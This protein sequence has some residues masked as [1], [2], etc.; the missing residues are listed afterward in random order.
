[1]SSLI[2]QSDLTRSTDQKPWYDTNVKKISIPNHLVTRRKTG[3]QIAAN[4][5]KKDSKHD[6]YLESSGSFN[7]VSFGGS[8]N[9]K[10]VGSDNRSRTGISSN[11]HD[12][13]IADISKYDETTNKTINDDLGGY[14]LGMDLPPSKSI[15]DLNDEILLSLDNPTPSDTFLTKDPKTY[16]NVFNAIVPGKLE[17]KEETLTI[18]PLDNCESAIVV[19]GYPERMANQVIQQFQLFGTILEEFEMNKVKQKYFT[20]PDKI[21]PIFSGP[22]WVKI[23]Y[24]NPA[25]ARDALQQNGT[26]FNGVILGVVPYT[27]DAIEKLQNR[28]LADYEDI[29]NSSNS[30]SYIQPHTPEITPGTKVSPSPKLATQSNVTKLDPKENNNVFLNNSNNDPTKPVDGN[31]KLSY[32]DRAMKAVF[33]FNEL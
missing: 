10:L 28:K 3:F 16:S 13:S 17:S 21:V 25:S 33:G 4:Q 27:K 20:K 11:S 9:R 8:P 14:D 32:W 29:G 22:S 7:L 12:T 1:M 2:Q 23:T 24:N 15:Y 5:S 18:N 31:E 26:V 30:K 19:F 6:D